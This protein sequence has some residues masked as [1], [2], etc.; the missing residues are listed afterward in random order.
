MTTS[1]CY[2]SWWLASGAWRCQSWSPL[3]S[4]CEESDEINEAVV[5]TSR[6]KSWLLVLGGMVVS[7]LSLCEE[8]SELSEAWEW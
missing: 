6:Y 3:D 2:K 7:K 5:I 4:M 8:S 1:R